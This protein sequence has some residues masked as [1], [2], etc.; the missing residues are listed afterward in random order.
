MESMTPQTLLVYQEQA[1]ILRSDP[2][3]P[4]EVLPLCDAVLDLCDA[5]VRRDNELECFRMGFEQWV[6]VR[7]KQMKKL[8]EAVREVKVFFERL[9]SEAASYGKEGAFLGLPD[10]Q[11]WVYDKVQQW[12]KTWKDLIA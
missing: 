1:H 8:Q 2:Q 7:M 6:R 10:I 9:E 5:V 3:T 12:N 4:K 11:E